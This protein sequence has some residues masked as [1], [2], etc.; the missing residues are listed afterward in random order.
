VSANRVQ[1]FIMEAESL[2][3]ILHNNICARML[4]RLRRDAQQVID[5]LGRNKDLLESIL[6]EKLQ[7]IDARRRELD[8]LELKTVEDMLRADKEYQTL[9]SANLEQAISARETV[10]QS[11]STSEH[12]TSSEAE[13]EVERPNFGQSGESAS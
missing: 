5:E 3:N 2:A 6:K 10:Q 1:Q 11:A 12:E 7:E 9:V 13:V 4:S 8:S